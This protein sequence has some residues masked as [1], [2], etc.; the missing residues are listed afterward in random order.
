MSTA[1]ACLTSAMAAIDQ[2][3]NC[4]DD[5]SKLLIGAK[6]RGLIAGYHARWDAA[7]IEPIAVEHVVTS[8]L[9]NIATGKQSRTFLI[10]GKLDV[11]AKRNGRLLVIDHKTTSDSIEDPNEPYWRQLVVE[12]QPS[13]YM[14]L[15]H[16]N[17]EHVNEAMWDV[18]RKPGISPKQ[19]SAKDQSRI[20]SEGKYFEMELLSS[21]LQ[22]MI[23]SGRESLDMYSAR[24]A[25]DCT[26]ERP[27]W[28]FARRT[29]PRLDIELNEYAGE[30]WDA[31]KEIISARAN[32]RWGR[33]PEAC[34]HKHSPCKF[35]GIC[36]GHDAP[37]SDR[38]TSKNSVHAE[39]PDLA[40]DGRDVLTNTR[41]STFRLCRRKHFYE[42]ELGIERQDEDETEALYFGN[43][44]HQAQE[45]WW[46]AKKEE[47]GNCNAGV[48]G[49]E[50]ASAAA[51][52]SPIA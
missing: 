1:S 25:H 13:H 51:D 50:F 36:S 10:A 9:Y 49:I 31:S 39:L 11:I 45:A 23:N 24:L 37:D 21:D 30:L 6:C 42:Y 41:L 18:V 34:M 43:V 14:W 27:D 44:W 46:L 40:G 3:M 52:H 35:L 5:P 20:V 12:S 47:Y 8:P 33:S 4:A 32:N 48:A 2:A 15:Q 38:W 26:V 22:Q 17:G 19:I 7:P 28:Y 16:M 29:V